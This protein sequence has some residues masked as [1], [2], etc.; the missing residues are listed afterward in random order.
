MTRIAAI[1]RDHTDYHIVFEPRPDGPTIGFYGEHP[2][3]AA[4]V[5]YFGRRFIYDGIAPR[6]RDGNHDVKL[7]RPGEWIVEPGLVY[8]IESERTAKAA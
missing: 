6:R 8:S 2:I 7:L 1:Q 4:I 5:D 3:A